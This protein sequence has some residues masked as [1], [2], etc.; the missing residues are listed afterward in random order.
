MHPVSRGDTIKML[1]DGEA[2]HQ[3]PVTPRWARGWV[4]DTAAE[5]RAWVLYPAN[6]LQEY[7]NQPHAPLYLLQNLTTC[8]WE[9]AHFSDEW[10]YRMAN[11][12]HL[13]LRGRHHPSRQPK[14]KRH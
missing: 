6:E 13:H 3:H 5:Q 14:S 1:F 2:W 7:L 12:H 4:A 9:F 8:T 10:E 11:W